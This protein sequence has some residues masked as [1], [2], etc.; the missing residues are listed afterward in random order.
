MSDNIA[1]IR[2]AA[3]ILLHVEPKPTSIDFIIS[4]PFAGMTCMPVVTKHPISD[5]SRT[6]QSQFITYLDI[7]TETGRTEWMKATSA[8]I[9]DAKN[10]FDILMLMHKPYQLMFLNM[11][12]PYVTPAT[13]GNALRRTWPHVENISTDPNLSPR[14]LA[15]LFKNSDPRTLMSPKDKHTFDSLPD[16]VTVYRGV[17]SV[18]KHIRNAFSWTTDKIVAEWFANRFDSKYKAVWTMNVPK[19]RILCCFDS[20]EHEVIVNMYRYRPTMKETVL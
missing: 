19:K 2:N 13:L 1:M 12:V 3:Q 11:C 20:S 14:D 8:R 10:I 9:N 17:T 15:K 7:N 6:F 5:Q 4:H 16:I 18:N